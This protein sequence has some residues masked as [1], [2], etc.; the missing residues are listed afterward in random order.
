MVDR[1]AH[2]FDPLILLGMLAGI[3]AVALFQNGVR[4]MGR[5]LAALVPLLT[6]DPAKDRDA[7]RAAMLKI[8]QVAQ[9][10]GLSCT[11]RVKTTHVF[12]TEA[13]RRLANCERIDQFELWAAQTLADR[14]DRHAAARNLWLS[15]ADAAPGLG[16]AGTIIGLVG[17]F[18]AMDDPAALGPSMAVA[19]LTTF[20]GVVIANLIAAPIAARLADLSERELVW[21]REV[22]TRMLAIARRERAPARRAAIREVA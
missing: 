7:A 14:A 6:A 17:M 2:L 8:D 9:L 4:G 21:Q 18:A 20:Y 11:D 12:L 5:G 16:M 15:I 22:V 10:R 3:V 13:A 1:L 19:L